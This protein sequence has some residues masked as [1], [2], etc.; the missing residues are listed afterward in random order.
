MTLAPVIALSHGGGPMPLLN[1]PNHATITSSLKNRVPKILSLSSKP[2]KAIVLITAHWTT[3]Q[4]TISNS[5][6]HSLLFDYYGFPPETY[7]LTYPAEGSPSI[8]S[9][10]DAAFKSEGLLPTLDPVRQWDHGVFIPML[11]VNPDASVPIVQLSVLQNEDAETHL[12]MGRALRKL[13][14]E[15]IAIVGS[16]FASLHSFP[17]MGK[18]RNSDKAEREAYKKEFGNPWNDALTDAVKK[19]STDWKDLQAWRKLPYADNFHPPKGG[20]H[21]MPLLV[22][23]GAAV[24]GEEAKYYKDDYMGQDIYT[25]YWG[26]EEVN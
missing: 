6:T 15:N 24:D 16:G 4:P 25:Y 18:L 14:E 2:P 9:E 21:F 5:S 19:A 7:E 13:R 11:L 10:I 8:A 3:P 1:D 23:A 20:E 12:R 22:C 26:G 17:V